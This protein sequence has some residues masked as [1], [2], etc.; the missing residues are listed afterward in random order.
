M[1]LLFHSLFTRIPILHNFK[2]ITH[3]FYNYYYDP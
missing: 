2:L 3:L 1:S